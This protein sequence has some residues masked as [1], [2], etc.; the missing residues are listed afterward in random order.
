MNY[1]WFTVLT[2]GNMG[3][4]HLGS[5]SNQVLGQF[6]GKLGSNYMNFRGCSPQCHLDRARMMPS[7]VIT[8]TSFC[9][10]LLTEECTEGTLK[11]GRGKYKG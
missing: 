5:N 7:I 3:C 4:G 6:A 10:A 1:T 9:A 2:E 11:A 8:H